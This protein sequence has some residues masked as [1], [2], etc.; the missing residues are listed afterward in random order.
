MCIRDRSEYASKYQLNQE[1]LDKHDIKFLMHPG[2][3][4]EGVEISNGLQNSEKSLISDQV[5]NGVW[6]RCAI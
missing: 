2:P 6:V 1:K 3:V 5:K 4:N